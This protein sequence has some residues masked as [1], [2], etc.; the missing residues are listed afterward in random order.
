MKLDLVRMTEVM[1]STSAMPNAETV[2]AS[3]VEIKKEIQHNG[4]DLAQLKDVIF[5]L[6]DKA[7]HDPR[8][9]PRKLRAKAE[10]RIFGKDNSAGRLKEKRD[11]I[12]D[13][14]MNWSEAQKAKEIA[15]MKALME[16]AKATGAIVPIMKG[17]AEIGSL[18]ERIAEV[19]K[20]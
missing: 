14:I 18:S 12:K 2:D 3:P 13:F 20:R 8:L 5:K 7:G 6:L 17:I 4:T 1:S 15:K 10:E 16:V 11:L 19:T 9:T